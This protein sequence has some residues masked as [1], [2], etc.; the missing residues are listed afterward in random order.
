MIRALTT[1]LA[2]LALAFALGAEAWAYPTSLNIMPTADVLDQGALAV[3]IES[4]GE[5]T[6]VSPGSEVGLFTQL[7]VASC[8]E[9]GWDVCGL[10]AESYTV[11][12]A[13]WRLVE[14]SGAR[15][16]VAVGLLDP[17]HGRLLS[18]W[19]VVATRYLGDVGVHG[20]YLDDGRGRAMLGFE[21]ALAERTWLLADWISGP[22]AYHTFG[23]YHE[24]TD[25]LSVNL[26]YGRGND[27][28]AGH[29]VGLNLR[30]EQA[31]WQP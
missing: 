13:K 21:S 29:F 24:L 26:Y 11:L 23:V 9:I 10:E 25:R 16:A 6:P 2:V 7:G 1:V 28:A 5:P 31:I 8:L 22:G 12:N 17:T 30:W 27:R 4:D 20:G 19:Y 15:P 14:E 18:P 3:E